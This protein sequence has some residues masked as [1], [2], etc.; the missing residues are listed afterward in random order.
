MRKFIAEGHCVYVVSPAERRKRIKTSLIEF[1][2]CKILKVCVGN[3][4]QCSLIEKGISTL[5]INYQYYNAIKKY[6][7]NINFDLILY[8]TP[9]VTMVDVVCKLK[10]KFGSFTYLM[11]KDI[12]PQNA[13]DLG[14]IREKGLIHKYFRYKET[15][16][17]KVSDYIGCMSPANVDYLLKNNGNCENKVGICPNAFEVFPLEKYSDNEIKSVRKEYMIPA[18]KLVLIYGGNLGRPQGIDFFL[19]CIDAAKNN[20]E[21]FFIVVGG[22]SEFNKISDFIEKNQINNIRLFQ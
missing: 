10:K 22:G 20:N 19:N 8:S 6:F 21:L 2:N 9:P 5:L 14:M 15:K 11:L 1:E 4:S 18:D 16:L 17:Y 12:F 7:N 3:Q 13:V